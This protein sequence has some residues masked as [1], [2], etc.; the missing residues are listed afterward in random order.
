MSISVSL[1]VSVYLCTSLN[2]DLCQSVSFLNVPEVMTYSYSCFS[3]IRHAYKRVFVI[4]LPLYYITKQR[5]CLFLP[6]EGKK[7]TKIYIH[8]K[9]RVSNRHKF[10]FGEMHSNA[11]L[12]LTGN[13]CCVFLYGDGSVVTKEARSS[14]K[15]GTRNVQDRSHELHLM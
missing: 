12:D 13:I 8:S 2:S 9:F 6:Y 1:H 10:P 15:E 7:K 5:E 4:Q 11:V 14:A 3:S